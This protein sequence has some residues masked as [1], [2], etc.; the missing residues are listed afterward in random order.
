MVSDRDT[1]TLHDEP[2]FMVVRNVFHHR[3]IFTNSPPP[4][5]CCNVHR[6]GSTH[7][8]HPRSQTTSSLEMFTV[9]SSKF[10]NWYIVVFPGLYSQGCRGSLYRAPSLFYKLR[11]SDLINFGSNRMQ[12]K[13]YVHLTHG[14]RYANDRPVSSFFRLHRP[15][16][17]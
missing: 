10:S 11:S 2:G 14:H 6:R 15:R 1:I 8:V 17:P 5:S 12:A 3:C 13:P 7:I 16:C 9:R 4:Y